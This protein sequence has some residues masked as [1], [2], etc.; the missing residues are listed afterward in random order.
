MTMLSN[1][2]CGLRD[3]N[4]KARSRL[5]DAAMRRRTAQEFAD[6]GSRDLD[7]V[8]ADL[9]C[10]R[11]DLEVLINNAPRSRPLLDA[12]ILRLGLEKEFA[13]G[14]ALVLR[15][16]ERRCAT[17]PTQTICGRWLSKGGAPGEYRL[18][19]PNAGNFDLLSGK[20]AA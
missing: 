12:M 3:L 18:F 11:E 17:C 13:L 5:H 14:E 16:I 6:L 2:L 9:G 4:A 7:R 10:T 15:D 8:L 1:L 20:T 19:C